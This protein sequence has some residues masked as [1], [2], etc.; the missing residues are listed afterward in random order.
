MRKRKKAKRESLKNNEFS[1]WRKK[2]KQY[3]SKRKCYR[4]KY[5]KIIVDFKEDCKESRK[6]ASNN[7]GI[8]MKVGKKK[9]VK[10]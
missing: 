10:L 5:R 2:L 9:N 8:I 7:Q 6:I 1:S 3:F 4:L